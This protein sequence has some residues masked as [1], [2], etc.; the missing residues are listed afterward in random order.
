MLLQAVNWLFFFKKRGIFS[1]Q[2]EKSVIECLQDL[3]TFHNVPSKVLWALFTWNQLSVLCKELYSYSRAEI[4]VYINK[5]GVL[6][7]HCCRFPFWNVF[8]LQMQTRRLL[9]RCVH[10]YRHVLIF[11]NSVVPITVKIS[12]YS[13]ADK[14]CDD[15]GAQVII[16]FGSYLCFMTK[17]NGHCL[18][19]IKIN[20]KIPVDF[21]GCYTVRR[22]PKRAR[23]STTANCAFHLFSWDSSD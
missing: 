14:I 10:K 13:K 12:I 5:A 6:Q 22:S 11:I 8:F 18:H 17:D 1:R 3:G 20:G 7:E 2:C 4:L 21:I 19:V 23:I 9:D 16:I 15:P